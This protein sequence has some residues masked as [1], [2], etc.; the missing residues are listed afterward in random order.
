[1]SKQYIYDESGKPQFVVLPVAEYEKLLSASEGEW[2]SLSAEADEHDDETIPHDVAGIMIEQEV[3]LQAAWRI[4]RGMSQHEV[5]QQ[6]GTTQSAISQL[7]R[8]DSKPQKKTRERL[9]KLYA[10]RP[11]QL[12][13]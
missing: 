13:L 11:E 7:E 1:M 2:E 9:A 3:S 4:Y 12:I 6:L 5:A 10:C 8:P